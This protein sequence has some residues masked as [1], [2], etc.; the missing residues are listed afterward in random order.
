MGYESPMFW[1]QEDIAW[2]QTIFC[3]L[4]FARF[5]LWSDWWGWGVGGGQKGLSRPRQREAT[6]PCWEHR[7]EALGQEASY[8]KV[9]SSDVPEMSDRWSPSSPLPATPAFSQ[10]D[11]VRRFFFSC[12]LRFPGLPFFF[13]P[14]VFSGCSLY[15]STLLV[16]WV[17]YLPSSSDPNRT[18]WFFV[19]GAGLELGETSEVVLISAVW[20]SAIRLWRKNRRRKSWMDFPLSWRSW[21]SDTAL[22]L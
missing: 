6:P 19:L 15:V 21:C 9:S 14:G 1:G 16:S 11:R 17:R 12:S 7:G 22:L 13:L 2:R 18:G 5:K 20:I 4:G 3:H 8:R 10:A